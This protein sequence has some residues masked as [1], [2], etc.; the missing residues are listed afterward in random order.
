MSIF[1]ILTFLFQLFFHHVFLEAIS[2][3]SSHIGT[4]GGYSVEFEE[5]GQVCYVSV[6]FW[7]GDSL[8][9]VTLLRFGRTVSFPTGHLGALAR[10]LS[11]LSTSPDLVGC[12]GC[13]PE[14]SETLDGSGYFKRSLQNPFRFGDLD[15]ARLLHKHSFSVFGR[16]DFF[17]VLEHLILSL[18]GILSERWSIGLPEVVKTI[19][20]GKLTVRTLPHV[21][22]EILRN[23]T[24]ISEYLSSSLPHQEMC[25]V[26]KYPQ[27]PEWT[28]LLDDFFL[29]RLE[30][31]YKIVRDCEY[32]LALTYLGVLRFGVMLA[33]FFSS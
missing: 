19:S 6:R 20:S 26:K 16:L 13:P 22:Q 12:S 32:F 23:W 7:R 29:P 15:L 9:K 1:Y 30:F 5:K 31:F 4:M 27:S 10:L 8:C 11:A 28:I 21:C 17:S 3:I 25:G 2:D 14:I 24:C 33:L 18:G